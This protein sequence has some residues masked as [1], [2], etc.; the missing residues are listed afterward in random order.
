[1]EDRKILIT[2]V[3]LVSLVIAS[4]Y[5][6]NKDDLFD[7]IIIPGDGSCEFTTVSYSADPVMVDRSLKHLA[8]RYSKVPTRKYHILKICLEN[9][10]LATAVIRA[11]EV[12][13]LNSGFIVDFCVLDGPK[14]EQAGKYLLKSISK[15]FKRNKIDLIGCMMCKHTREYKLLKKAGFLTLPKRLLPHN[16]PVITRVNGELDNGSI[17]N[18]LDNWFLTFGDYDVM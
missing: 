12:Y 7:V 4:C 18:T 13:G 9:K 14:A 17:I 10:I 11:R 16:N 1:M 2:L 15:Y 3:L 6:D 5:N 8:W